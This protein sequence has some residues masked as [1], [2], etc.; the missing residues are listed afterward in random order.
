MPDLI[1]GVPYTA[2]PLA[3]LISSDEN[4]PMI[5]RRKEAKGYGTKKILE[6][7]FK[8]GDECL[9]IEVSQSNIAKKLH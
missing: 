4:V 8:L 9:I 5:I 7:H 2:L 6:G 3:T 1:C